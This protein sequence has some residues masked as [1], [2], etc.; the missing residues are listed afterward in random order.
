MDRAA[1]KH[2]VHLVT[3]PRI[4]NLSHHGLRHLKRYVGKFRLKAVDGKYRRA[5]L[6]RHEECC[7]MQIGHDL[8]HAFIHTGTNYRLDLNLFSTDD[9]DDYWEAWV[10]NLDTGDAEYATD[11]IDGGYRP[12]HSVGLVKHAGKPGAFSVDSISIVGLQH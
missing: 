5:T 7:D 12:V 4:A 3:P 2:G 9:G 11:L 6:R 1:G 8:L 10:T